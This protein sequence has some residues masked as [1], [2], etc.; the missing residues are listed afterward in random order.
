M[1][2][3]EFNEWLERI[4]RLPEIPNIPIMRE[5]ENARKLSPEEAKA[6]N[7]PTCVPRQDPRRN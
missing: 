5:F 4:G 6:L 3:S 2:D 7:W 1:K